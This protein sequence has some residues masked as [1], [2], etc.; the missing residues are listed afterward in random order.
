MTRDQTINQLISSSAADV[1][2]ARNDAC[3]MKLF[4]EKRSS[5]AISAPVLVTY[6]RNRLADEN[7]SEQTAMFNSGEQK[8]S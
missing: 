8:V 2:D 1:L 6:I 7:R 3:T 5:T 4:Y